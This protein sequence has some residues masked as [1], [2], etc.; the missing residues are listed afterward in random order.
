MWVFLVF[1][2]FGFDCVGF[3]IVRGD[4]WLDLSFGALCVGGSGLQL[5]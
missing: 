2:Y 5:V 4:L 3:A 1:A